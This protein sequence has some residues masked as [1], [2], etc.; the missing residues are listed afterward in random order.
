MKNGN[1]IL[2]EDTGMSYLVPDN[3]RDLINWISQLTKMKSVEKKRK[4]EIKMK[5][6][7]RWKI[8]T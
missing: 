8:I 1:D 2:E 7:L 4:I 3:L 5:K 6:N